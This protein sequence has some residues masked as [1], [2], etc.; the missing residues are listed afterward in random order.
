MID[1]GV[2]ADFER[3]N[4]FIIPATYK[5][6]LKKYNGYSFVGGKI[7]YSLDDIIEMNKAQKIQFFQPGYIAIGDDGAGIIF[8]MKQENNSSKIYLVDMGDCNVNSCYHIIDDF[9]HWFNNNCY[10]HYD[11]DD[12][13]AIVDV[14]LIKSPENYKMDLLRIK[15]AFSLDISAKELLL[16]SKKVP[17]RLISGINIYK[18]KKIIKRINQPDIFRFEKH[19]DD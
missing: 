3:A 12:E 15:K 6:F 14:F 19:R 2:L 9:F 8:L 10:V 1:D 17:C 18:A 13:E 4:G 7:L 11:A 16:V 5:K